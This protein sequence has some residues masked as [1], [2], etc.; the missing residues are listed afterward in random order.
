MDIYFNDK[1]D[2]EL[3]QVIRAEIAADNKKVKW[4]RIFTFSNSQKQ[5]GCI[6]VINPLNVSIA[7]AMPWT[8]GVL[9][10]IF[11]ELRQTQKCDVMILQN[12][13]HRYT[14]LSG[15]WTLYR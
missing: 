4:A 14:L 7:T 5:K 8:L 11:N 15:P 3:Y 9:Q 1:R 10:F 2:D 12:W 6:I 13:F